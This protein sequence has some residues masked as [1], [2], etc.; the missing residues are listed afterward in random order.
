MRAK[1]Q[2]VPLPTS[3]YLVMDNTGGQ[4]TDE[5]AN[6]YHIILKEDFNIKIIQQVPML[7]YTN[8]MDLGVW[9]GLQAAVE[10]DTT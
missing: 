6:E 3:L 2:W 10:R 1:Y 9:A 4:G 5:Y 7:P 8:V